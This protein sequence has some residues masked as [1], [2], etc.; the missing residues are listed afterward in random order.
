MS[1]E[2]KAAFVS[3]A[4]RPAAGEWEGYCSCSGEE[5]SQELLKNDK[6]RESYL[7]P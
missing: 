1:L 4:L 7:G 2:G 3:G 5:W 6:V